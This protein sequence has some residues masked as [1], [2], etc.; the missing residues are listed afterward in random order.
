MV[1]FA[2]ASWNSLFTFTFSSQEWLKVSIPVVK[3]FFRFSNS[4]FFQPVLILIPYGLSIKISCMHTLQQQYLWF[5]CFFSFLQVLSSKSWTR[6]DVFYTSVDLKDWYLCWYVYFSCSG[7][8]DHNFTLFSELQAV[9]II[10]YVQI[11]GVI[12]Y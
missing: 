10:R 7:V 12:I 8:I 6:F 3:S 9:V 4:G 1:V 5:L 2:F 11:H